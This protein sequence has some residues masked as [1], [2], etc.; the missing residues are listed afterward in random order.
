MDNWNVIRTAYQVAQLGTISA[1][2]EALGVHRSTVIR[3]IDALEAQL[4]EK[5]FLRHSRGYTPTEVGLDLMRVAKAA[6]E[7]FSQLVG[8]T[9][10]ITT[11]LSGEFIVTSLYV[12]SPMLIPVLNVFQT[13]LDKLTAT[14]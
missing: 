5:V 11:D 7:Q 10:G 6:D 14:T 8:R 13:H 4:G 1:A 3:H 2:A 12:V 9:K